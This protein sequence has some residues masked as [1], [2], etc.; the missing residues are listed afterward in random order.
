MCSYHKYKYVSHIL[1]TS[2]FKFK[3]SHDECVIRSSNS[4]ILKSVGKVL[5]VMILKLEF[6]VFL[7]MKV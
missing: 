7:D 1:N 6:Y 5:Q 3:Y 2:W 4:K